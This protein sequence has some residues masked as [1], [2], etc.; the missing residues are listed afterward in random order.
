MALLLVAAPTAAQQAEGGPWPWDRGAGWHVTLEPHDNSERARLESARAELTLGRPRRARE[1]LPDSLSD[2]RLRA[3]A[4]AIDAEALLALDRPV[5][6]AEQFEA[7]AVLVAGFHAGVLRARA[8]AAWEAAGHRERAHLAYRAAVADLPQATPWLALR[9]ARTGDDPDA[10]ALTSRPPPG[11]EGLARAARAELLLQFGDT[12]RAI[13]ALIAADRRAAAARLV[14]AADPVTARALAY[15]ALEAADTAEVARALRLLES[16][17]E[18]LS[19][20]DLL[21]AARA[22]ERLRDDPRAAGWTTAAVRAGDSS[23]TTA[24]L[25]GDRLDRAGDRRAAIAAYEHGGATGAFRAARLRV[26]LRDTRGARTALTAFLA[27]HPDHADAPVAAYVLADL[28]GDRAALAAV[29]ERWPAHEVASRIRLQLAD[30]NLQSGDTVRA[31]SWYVAESAHARDAFGAAFLLAQ[32]DR[33]VG[34]TAAWRAAMQRI[35]DRDPLGFYGHAAR[36]TAGLPVPDFRLPPP[37]GGDVGVIEVLAQ[38]DLLDAAGF[39]EEAELLVAEATRR[40][41]ADPEA[42]LDLAEGLVARDRA[43][44][45]IAI[46]WRTNRVLP[47]T[48]PRLVRVL[49]PWPER[50]LVLAEAR[51]FDLDPWLVAGLI[52]QESSFRTR[53]RSR[54]G[55]RGLMQLMPATALAVARRLGVPWSDTDRGVPDANVHVGVAHLAALLRQFNGEVPTALAAYNAGGTPTLRWRRR[56]GTADPVTFVEAITYPETRGYVRAVLRNAALYRILYPDP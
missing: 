6:A 35:A 36:G 46:G 38:L 41:G 21:L 44:E 14:L 40:V 20:Q 55:A 9:A 24:V 50:E 51:K 11:A 45:A 53:A 19:A 27:G 15:G 17:L 13:D 30:E 28:D 3:P 5:D 10:V 25:L 31:R 42:A 7:A 26:R 29:A 39:D 43:P 52:R 12:T 22:A 2:P 54:A 33:R 32:L 8:G 37:S 16:Q 1:L 23:A 4:L 48:H 34:D 47:L 49:F 18:P 56:A